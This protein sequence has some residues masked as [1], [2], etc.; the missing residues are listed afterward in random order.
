MEQVN[1]LFTVMAGR[2]AYV[3]YILDELDEAGMAE[4]AAALI[5][6]DSID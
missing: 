1:E 6:S 4:E 3:T 5:S 2:L